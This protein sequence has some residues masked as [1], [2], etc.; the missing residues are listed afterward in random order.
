MN[1]GFFPIPTSIPAKLVKRGTVT[2]KLLYSNPSSED[3]TEI[4]LLELSP[5]AEIDLHTHKFDYEI[6]YL[7]DD[8]LAFVCQIENSHSLEND[9]NSIMK[10]ISIKSKKSFDNTH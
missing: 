2:K 5:K 7:V 1:I 8:N 6:Y 9:T 10:V 4:A 3:V